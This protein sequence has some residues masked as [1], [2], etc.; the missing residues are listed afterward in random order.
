MKL[1]HKR[2]IFDLLK[3]GLGILYLF[4]MIIMVI[5]AFQPKIEVL[6]IPFKLSIKNPT[7]DNFI[8]TIQYM[9]VLVWLK[10]TFIV[11]GICLPTQLVTALLTAYGFAFFNFK[12]KK[13]LFALLLTTMMIPGEV[14]TAT[15]FKMM[16][17][18][19]LINTYGALTITHL[20][21]VACVF[22]FRQNMLSLPRSL[23]DA[24]QIDGCGYMPYFYK[25]MVPL[26]KPL[27]VTRVMSGFIAQY[28]SH[29]WPQLVTTTSDMRTV[30]AGI[31]SIMGAE[32]DGVS[33]AAATIV[34]ILPVLIFIFGMERITSGMTAG[35]VKS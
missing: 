20:T 11:I 31:A 25:V 5:T 33:L 9:D 8:H 30:Q 12:G 7:F 29:M 17:K 35:A 1:K 6:S 4:P 32:H 24:A 18:W 28:N 15:L 21:S 34:L 3:I 22:M 27:I 19:D 10:N 26:C 14:V 16:V 2:L 23:W 13:F